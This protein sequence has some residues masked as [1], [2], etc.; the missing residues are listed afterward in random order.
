MT[1]LQPRIIKRSQILPTSSTSERAAPLVPPPARCKV[2]KTA[3]LVEIGGRPAA[4]EVTCSCGETTLIELEFAPAR[5][6][7]SATEERKIPS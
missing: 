5:P 1:E 3:T 6:A 7:E 2:Q 4:I